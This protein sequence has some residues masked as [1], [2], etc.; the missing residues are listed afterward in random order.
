MN[1]TVSRQGKASPGFVE[2]VESYLRTCLK[3]IQAQE[4]QQGAGP[5][6]K[7]VGRPLELPKV[8]LWSALLMGVLQRARGVRE[9]WRSVVQQGDDICD[10]T[11]YDR[12]D[13]EGTLWLEELFAQLSALLA[14]WLQ[15]LVEQQSWSSLAPF[16]RQVL[17][18]DETTLDPVARKLPILRHLK[19]GT[20]DTMCVCSCGDASTICPM[21][22]KTPK[23]MRERCSRDWLPR[24]YCSST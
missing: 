11:L 5:D 7:R 15:P 24:P 6:A 12:L 21:R 22:C 8:V 19:K 4:E 14:A 16:A 13:Q 20:V 1:D 3:R 9:I 18:L 2:Q 10:Q 23:C 17:V